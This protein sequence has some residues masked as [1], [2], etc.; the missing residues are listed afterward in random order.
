MRRAIL[1]LLSLLIVVSVFG[2]RYQLA[3]DSSVI[4]IGEPLSF[5]LSLQLPAGQAW[6]VLPLGDTLGNLDILSISPADTTAV[7]QD[8]LITQQ[9]VASAYD[10]GQ[11]IAGPCMAI[12]SSGDT[13]LSNLF[14]VRVNTLDVDTAQP[15]KDIY[16]PL[17]MPYTWRD[18]LPYIIAV[19]VL[20]LLLSVGY[21]IWKKHRQKVQKDDER[22]KPKEPPHIWARAQLR[23]LEEKRLLEKGEEKQ[24]HSRV[25]DIIRLYLEYRFAYY[26]MESTT[27]QIELEVLRLDLTVAAKETLIDVLKR[28]D[29]V[30]FAKMWLP[31]DQH[32]K[33][34]QQAYLFIDLTKPTEQPADTKSKKP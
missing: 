10:S 1:F 7:K 3:A 32:L 9:I 24:Y 14:E 5:T 23:L 20:L 22:P 28:A 19:I 29:L 15:F 11:F 2:Q 34:V 27:E 6:R 17:E 31:M 13:L 33:S 25:S 16:E 12:S 18:F 30:K 8:V 26:A 21:Y 4:R